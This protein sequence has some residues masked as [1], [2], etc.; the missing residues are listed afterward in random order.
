MEDRRFPSAT[1]TEVTNYEFGQGAPK[2][3][4]SAIN[5]NYNL[6]R[7]N[8]PD[9]YLLFGLELA[10][11]V[12]LGNPLIDPDEKQLLREEVFELLEMGLPNDI[13]PESKYYGFLTVIENYFI[14]GGQIP[15]PSVIK[16]LKKGAE[17]YAEMKFDEIFNSE[18][19]EGNDIDEIL[20]EH[21]YEIGDLGLVFKFLNSS[22][23]KERLEEIIDFLKSYTKYFEFGLRSY[24][25]ED[26]ID[27][28]VTMARILILKSNSVEVS[29]D[30]GIVLK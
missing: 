23:S 24:G 20:R 16:K 25:V 4:E 18:I 6:L 19:E 11:R 14:T 9:P 3:V 27:L 28:L 2:I 1:R 26:S 22:K 17:E 15:D 21:A 13:D 8:H 12:L 29:I 7:K 30:G 10:S 5:K